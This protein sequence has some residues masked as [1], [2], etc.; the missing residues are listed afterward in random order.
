M[1][2]SIFILTTKDP[3]TGTETLV[4]FFPPEPG[5]NNE[6]P[7]YGDGNNCMGIGKIY[8][9]I[10]NEGPLYGDGNGEVLIGHDD[11]CINNEGPLYGDGNLVPAYSVVKEPLTT[12][13]PF[14]GAETCGLL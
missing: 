13:D 12:K 6:G 11:N 3:F 9:I 7:L 14:M 2:S 4:T 10:N 5:I 1:I 8:S